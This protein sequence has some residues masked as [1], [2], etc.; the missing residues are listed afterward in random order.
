MIIIKQIDITKGVQ[1][2]EHN[3]DEYDDCRREGALL[4]TEYHSWNNCTPDL[5]AITYTSHRHDTVIVFFLF[6]FLRV[7]IS[8]K[9]GEVHMGAFAA[10]EP[11]AMNVRH[12][13]H[14]FVQF[15][16]V[17][18]DELQERKGRSSP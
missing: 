16:E 2:H 3:D 5:Y 17:F 7:N 1:I 6:Q 10:A 15:E 14:S 12:I 11:A 13:G 8:N 4:L 18:T 9:G